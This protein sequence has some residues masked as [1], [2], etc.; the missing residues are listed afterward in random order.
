M[1]VL[2]K[3]GSF[4]IDT[5]TKVLIKEN[6]PVPI[7]PKVYDTLLVLVEGRGNVLTKDDLMEKIW[8]DTA[9][10]ENNLQQ[11]ISTLRKVL[12]EAEDGT[13]YI[14]TLPKRGYRFAAKVE[15][16]ADDEALIV[17]RH[18]SSH[19]IIDPQ[20]KPIVSAKNIT[21]QAQTNLAV[22]QNLASVVAL[23]ALRQRALALKW[24]LAAGAAVALLL[25]VGVLLVL[26]N[27]Q[28]FQARQNNRNLVLRQTKTFGTRNDE[29]QITLMNGR[30]SPDGKMVAYSAINGNQS[31]NILVKVLDSDYLQP[32][33]KEASHN[34]CPLWSADGSEVAFL[35]DR[36]D[37]L[38][39]WK[40]H[41]MGGAATLLHTF[42]PF[43]AS[44]ARTKPWLAFWSEDG[45][46]IYYEWS[47]NFFAL[48]I[49]SKEIT[50]LTDF[51]P[52]KS[53]A[54][55]FRLSPDK[56]WIAYMDRKE[57][58][59]DVWI[60]SVKS[61]ASVQ[62][63]ND[64]IIEDKPVWSADGKS[65]IYTASQDGRHDLKMVDLESKK[66]ISLLLGME[67]GDIT[68]LSRDGSKLLYRTRKDESNLYKVNLLSGEERKIT[69]DS[70]VEFWPDVSPSGEAI[71]FQA[72]RGSNFQLNRNQCLILM[73]SLAPESQT[74]QM[75][76]SASQAQWSPDGKHLAFLQE[77]KGAANL[78][79]IKAIGGEARQVSEGG[80]NIGEFTLSP[81][82]HT[83]DY[84]W[85]PESSKLAYISTK[86]ESQNLWITNIDGSGEV[87]LSNNADAQVVLGNPFWSPDGKKIAY[88]SDDWQNPQSGSRTCKVWVANLE[89]PANPEVIFQTESSLKLVGWTAEDELIIGLVDKKETSIADSLD[90]DIYKISGK[91]SQKITTL[92]HT[93]FL[94]LHL[95]PDKKT[96]AFVSIQDRKSNVYT[97]ALKGGE[98][99]QITKNTDP[100]SYFS[101]LA[102]SP[103]GTFLCYGRQER[104]NSF[105]IFEGLK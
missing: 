51:D 30:L 32:L 35:S 25:A 90:V 48:N 27:S 55:A 56:E 4:F 2:Y 86:E 36:G 31:E 68:D 5:Q 89:N 65:L 84:S 73:K 85:S 38:G 75:A 20:P 3:F 21:P 105:T 80:I 96:I 54:R 34:W 13:Q 15:E 43:I 72:V 78:Y 76:S 59:F 93:Y 16:I 52:D 61:G 63:T 58:Q 103:D 42:T 92:K 98:I 24:K 17:E 45:G 14:E 1:K 39:L 47:S 60:R 100:T 12:G 88:V 9:V 102:W 6:K 74:V 69:S 44:A 57:N 83:N 50:R 22:A 23:P 101:S 81:Y 97:Y 46:T 26:L 104:L 67:V 91:I 99:K 10:E 40:V 53:M 77:D 18:T 87:K 95:S 7:K 41:H 82:N 79:T 66:A 37:Q 94:N 70:G 8:S 29:E 28:W 33:T 49:L 62:I 71:V 19:I 64:S 11:N